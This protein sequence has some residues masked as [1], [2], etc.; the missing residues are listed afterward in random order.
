MKI[1]TLERNIG[2]RNVSLGFSGGEKI[3]GFKSKRDI[4]KITTLLTEFGDKINELVE[5]FNKR[6]NE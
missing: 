6:N 3:T 1:K 4:E 5:A 2:I